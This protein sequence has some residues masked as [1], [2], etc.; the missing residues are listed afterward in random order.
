MLEVLF[1]AGVS[2]GKPRDSVRVGTIRPMFRYAVFLSLALV[3]ACTPAPSQPTATPAAVPTTQPVASAA[4]QASAAP[5][6]AASPAAS[7]SPVVAAPSAGVVASPSPGVAPAPSPGVAA[8][9]SPAAAPPTGP[10]GE[11]LVERS[12]E[13]RFQLDLQVADAALAPFL[14]SGWS[15][16]VATSGAAKDANLRAVFIDR[17]TVNGPTGQPVG[18]SG[19]NQLV[20]L[21][22]PVKD[23]TGA[24]VQLV[25]GGITSDPS[26]VPGPF[27]NYLQATSHSMQRSSQAGENPPIMDSQDWAFQAQGDEHLEL[28]VTYERGSAALGPA[29][30]TRFYSAKNPTFYQLSRQEQ[31]LDILRNVTTAP[32]DRVHDFS[33]VCSGGSYA[34]IC[35]GAKVLS[36]D[37]ILWIN[38]LVFQP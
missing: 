6:P 35:A 16:N 38:R 3:V 22:A 36:W 5:K 2:P 31:V 26:D 34:A 10:N 18:S 37:N 29:S 28:H 25:I 14:P 17:V 11:K 23:Q 21:V 4:P 27:G 9:P 7:P 33:F 32:P 19:T 12:A 8:S 20:Y 24:A 30:D 13:V 1:H 15:S